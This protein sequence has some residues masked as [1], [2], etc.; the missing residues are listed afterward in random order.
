MFYKGFIIVSCLEP[1][2]LSKIILKCK[3]NRIFEGGH[4]GRASHS[5]PEKLVEIFSFDKYARKAK[6]N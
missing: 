5:T 1:K 4:S 3:M 6:E 2:F